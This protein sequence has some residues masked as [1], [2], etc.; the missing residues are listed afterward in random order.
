MHPTLAGLY[1]FLLGS[2]ARCAFLS[3][4]MCI[5]CL[6]SPARSQLTC[7]HSCPNILQIA[8]NL[9]EGI[10]STQWDQIIRGKSVDLNQLLSS[11]HYVQLNEERKGCLGNAEVVFAITE[12]KQQIKT[13]AAS[14]KVNLALP[15]SDSPGKP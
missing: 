13:G 2:P 7:G 6:G 12:S 1:P 11:M 3:Y 5:Y 4:F 8:Y 10:S 14:R 9:P 15:S